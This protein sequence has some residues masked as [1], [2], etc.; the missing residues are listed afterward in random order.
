MKRRRLVLAGWVR[1]A[2]VGPADNFEETADKKKPTLVP[3]IWPQIANW[4][5]KTRDSRLSQRE[6]RN[7]TSKV[8][9][10][11]RIIILSVVAIY[12][13]QRAAFD[14]SLGRFWQFL[15]ET[16]WF[17]HDT[18]EPFLVIVS[19]PIVLLGYYLLD[20]LSGAS[21]DKYRIQAEERGK[22]TNWKFDGDSL[23]ELLLYIVPIATF[24]FIY[25]RRK[26]PLESPTCGQLVRYFTCSI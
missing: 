1:M 24:D 25:P 21:L 8:T 15:L 9:I 12:F 19:F 2:R 14:E 17:R 6:M 18:F 16:W 11:V 22:G 10:A 26:L 13:A 3:A 7:L 4:R 20:T 23:Q 5:R